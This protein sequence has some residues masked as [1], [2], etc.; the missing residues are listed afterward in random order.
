[1][2]ETCP[3]PP[4]PSTE[5]LKFGTKHLEYRCLVPPISTNPL[6][7]SPGRFLIRV[8]VF[9]R[10][11]L[12]RAALEPPRRPALSWHVDQCIRG[13]ENEGCVSWVAM[14]P[15]AGLPKEMV[16]PTIGG[17]D[18]W[19]NKIRMQ[20]R[21][22]NPEQASACFISYP[23]LNSLRTFDIFYAFSLNCFHLSVIYC[24]CC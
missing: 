11:V 4:V 21:Q 8:C 10:N 15:P 14:Y 5:H 22:T 24:L 18:Y 20:H 19:A 23:E 3:L 13:M 6:H 17:S 1:M 16:E 9:R 2:G 7:L 12:N